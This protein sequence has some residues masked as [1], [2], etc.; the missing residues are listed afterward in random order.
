MATPTALNIVDGV[1]ICDQCSL[2]M[3]PQGAILETM[4]YYKPVN[5]HSHDDNCLNQLYRCEN[6]HT[7][8]VSKR[9]TCTE[10]DWK[11]KDN[12]GCHPNLKVDEW[13]K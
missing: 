11:G 5:G 3:V 12:C 4:V 2:P 9:R 6:N 13:P 10:C 7:A 1:L 8:N